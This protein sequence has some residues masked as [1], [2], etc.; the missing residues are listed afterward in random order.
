MNN[1]AINMAKTGS[2]K[3]GQTYKGA[4]IK[5]KTEREEELLSRDGVKSSD[6][7][8]SGKGGEDRKDT[9]AEDAGPDT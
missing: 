3:D 1:F 6:T 5:R 8:S 4:I 7:S 9:E 2:N